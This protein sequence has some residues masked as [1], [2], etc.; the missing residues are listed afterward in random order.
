MEAVELTHEERRCI[1]YH[2]MLPMYAK[3]EDA[4]A[5]HVI[6]VKMGFDTKVMYLAPDAP[7]VQTPGWL[8][9]GLEPE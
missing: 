1:A 9:T 5:A 3:E 4:N 8:V 2:L 6:L 7:W